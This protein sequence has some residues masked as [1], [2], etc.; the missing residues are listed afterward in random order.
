MNL[1]G[2]YYYTAF[3]FIVLQ[4]CVI[5]SD[6]NSRDNSECIS[7]RGCPDALICKSG[8]CSTDEAPDSSVTVELLP[9]NRLRYAPQMLSNYSLKAGSPTLAM[10][11]NIT[12]EST[13]EP[14]LVFDSSRTPPSGTLL[15][16]PKGNPGGRLTQRTR[17]T[18]G[19]FSTTVAPGEYHL[20]F[21]PDPGEIIPNRSGSTGLLPSYHWEIPLETN[22][23]FQRQLTSPDSNIEVDVA[24]SYRLS[25]GGQA[26]SLG[27]AR[28]FAKSDTSGSRS[29]DC[30]LQFD[31]TTDSQ[32]KRG[33]CT[34][35]LPP[36]SGSYDLVVQPASETS[37]VPRA[38]YP[39][40]FATT[41]RTNRSDIEKSLGEI[42]GTVLNQRI[43]LDASRLGSTETPLDLKGSKLIATAPIGTGTARRQLVF[44]EDLTNQSVQ[45]RMLP[46]DYRLMLIPPV[47]SKLKIISKQVEVGPN[48]S[49]TTNIELTS[50]RRYDIEL[51]RWDGESVSSAS[52]DLRRIKPAGLPSAGLDRARFQFQESTGQLWL[53]PSVT[54]R[55]LV[56]PKSDEMLPRTPF[57]FDASTLQE[58]NNAIIELRV[59]KPY[60]FR[61]RVTDARQLKPIDSTLIRVRSS[62]GLPIGYAHTDKRGLFR[63]RLPYSPITDRSP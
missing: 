9:D 6:D 17:V 36:E 55:G 8:F 33:T 61:G 54:Y 28:V 34:L 39:D 13:D 24:L 53:D 40:E 20:T 51:A 27:S 32:T 1:R 60:I 42:N 14:G 5:S 50:K 56:I 62:D 57:E 4:G 18:D 58:S 37:L 49:S 45:L 46:G 19:K 52:L 43:E 11:P 25:G 59:A 16:E 7:D 41:E 22:T 31:E 2:L 15:L 26:N 47:R 29:T 12:V 23:V 10:E 48:E 35:Q 3:S 63:M 38:V 30:L 44:R 21:L